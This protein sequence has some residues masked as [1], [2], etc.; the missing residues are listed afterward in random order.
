[1]QAEERKYLQATFD[2]L[3]VIVIENNAALYATVMLSM[4]K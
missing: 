1:V 4:T 3:E 2:D